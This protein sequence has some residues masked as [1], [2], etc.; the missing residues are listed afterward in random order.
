VFTRDYIPNLE[1]LATTGRCVTRCT[2]ATTTRTAIPRCALQKVSYA[3][4]ANKTGGT[5][6]QQGEQ[7]LGR[8]TAKRGEV[9]GR[10]PEST[11]RWPLAVTTRSGKMWTKLVTKGG[12]CNSNCV[13]RQLENHNLK[14]QER[15]S[16]MSSCQ[17]GLQASYKM[18]QLDD[19]GLGSLQ[20]FRK[21][22]ACVTN[23]LRITRKDIQLLF[24]N[25]I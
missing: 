11:V 6:G 19:D 24:Y 17:C 9:S 13:T 2:V 15:C 18:L 3:N 23:K 12:T 14:T 21:C 4:V 5:Q 7:E 25:L 1:W 8:K 20:S 10:G 22:I 16:T